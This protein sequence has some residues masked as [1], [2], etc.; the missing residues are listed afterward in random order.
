[1]KPIILVA[2]LLLSL[3]L[4][5]M[6]LAFQTLVQIP[7]TMLSKRSSYSSCVAYGGITKPD[8]PGSGGGGQGV[9]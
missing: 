2:I 1:M 4:T 8:E 5:P 7:K 3:F 6:A 9:I